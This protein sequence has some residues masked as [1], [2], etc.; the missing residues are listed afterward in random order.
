MSYNYL[1]LTLSWI[2]YFILHS[3]LAS[4]QV[5]IYVKKISNK[6]F[7]Y[8]RL[9]YTLFATVSLFFIIW[10]QYTFESPLLINSLMLKYFSFLLLVLPGFAIMSA[11]IFKYFKLLSGIRSIYLATPPAELK[12]NGIHKYVRH[13][14]YLGTLLF[15]WG[16]FFIFPLLNNLIAVVA[17][18]VYVLVGIKF[19]EKKLIKEFGND[20]EEYIKKVPGL[21]PKLYNKK[22]VAF[23][24]PL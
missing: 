17:I 24:P 4:T 19:E 6:F 23:Q 9:A 21:I 11:S 7:R 14:L 15:V 2:A 5:K 20:Y 16:L 3:V 12:L 1:I 10:F 22:R 18:T 13:P 8:Y